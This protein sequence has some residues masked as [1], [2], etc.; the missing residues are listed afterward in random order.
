MPIN[1]RH[2]N[3]QSVKNVILSKQARLEK[4]TFLNISIQSELLDLFDG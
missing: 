3:T 2:F 1:L 4:I